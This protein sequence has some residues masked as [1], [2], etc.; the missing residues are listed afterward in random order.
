MDNFN[1]GAMEHKRNYPRW[2]RKTL[3]RNNC[4]T[5]RKDSI[6]EM[7]SFFTK[8]NW[9]Y[10]EVNLH[11]EIQRFMFS[12]DTEDFS[13]LEKA[14]RKV[15]E[16]KWPMAPAKAMKSIINTLYLFSEYFGY[17]E[18]TWP[19]FSSRQLSIL[20][21]EMGTTQDWEKECKLF[22]SQLFSMLSV[23]Q[24]GNRPKTDFFSRVNVV[25]E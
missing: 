21:S 25:Q 4:E 9:S 17:S 15:Y 12:P 2:L 10:A 16:D 5:L 8:D 24:F 13:L 6:Q 7:V 18:S 14:I 20:L 19:E 1:Y 23:P 3:K 22:W 11:K